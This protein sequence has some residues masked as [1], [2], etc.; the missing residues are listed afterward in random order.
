MVLL[1][2]QGVTM[3]PAVTEILVMAKNEVQVPGMVREIRQ[4][5]EARD[6]DARYLAEPWYQHG[7]IISSLQM[8]GTAYNLV[9]F[10]VLFLASFVVVNTMLMI[11]NERRRE[12]G[13]MG[14]LG[15]HPGEIRQLFMYEGGIMG[16]FG[17]A[18]GV[19]VGGAVLKALSTAGIPIPGTASIDRAFLIPAKLYPEFGP[20][21]IGFAFLAGIAVTL[22][23]VFWPARQAAA[24]EPT[25]ALRV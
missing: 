18:L 23:A 25:E 19:I 8:A 10:F 3:G 11:V 9:Y 7:E 12:I 6:A 5:L 14:A 15:L 17:S 1:E 21:V 2:L 22:V 24:M 4:I 16:A 20:G 13:M